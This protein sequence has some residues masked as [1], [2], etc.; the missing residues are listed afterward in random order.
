ME[1]THRPSPRIGALLVAALVLYVALGIYAEYWLAVI[2]PHPW[3]DDFNIYYR[4]LESAQ[5][6]ASPYLPYII[7]VSFVYHPFALTL[8]SVVGVLGRVPASLV[9]AALN[10]SGYALSAWLGWRLLEGPSMQRARWLAVLVLIGAFAPFWEMVHIG[11]IN[12]IVLACLLLALHWAE[13]ERPIPAGIALALAIVLKSSPLV[14]LLYFLVTRR[15]Q[16]VISALVAFAGLSLIAWAQ[17]GTQVVADYFAVLGRL[18]AETH[19]DFYNHSLTALAMRIAAAR[20][21][22]APEAALASIHR[23]GLTLLIGA[24]LGIGLTLPRAD[25][26]GRVWLF[27]L[28]LALMTVASPLVWYHHNV[29]LLLPALALLADGAGTADRDVPLSGWMFWFGVGLLLLIQ[30]ER[31]F[32]QVFPA[33]PYEISGPDRYLAGRLAISGLPVLIAQGALIAARVARRSALKA[34]DLDQQGESHVS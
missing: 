18:G 29:F 19:P 1:P 10:T 23:L 4:A 7:G 24:A 26:R 28:L 27:G 17:F 12:G 3:A 6:G 5:A 15:W 33:M 22:A 16:V 31:L 20:G 11:Q 9:W 13:T 14:L 21:I 30:S 25:R 34:S 8:V 32:E 2:Q